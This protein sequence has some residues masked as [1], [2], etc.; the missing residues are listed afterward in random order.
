MK[1][2]SCGTPSK[3]KSGK[4]KKQRKLDNLKDMEVIWEC[5]ASAEEIEQTK[6]QI[7]DIL[8]KKLESCEKK[9]HKNDKNF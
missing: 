4:K 1:K 5:N 9:T 7:F 6:S 8:F 2:T 3:T